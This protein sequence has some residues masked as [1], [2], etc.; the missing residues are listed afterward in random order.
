MKPQ[1]K[2]E[3]RLRVAQIL[4]A[5]LVLAQRGRCFTSLS[6]DE[7][8]RE[9]GFASSS[10]I[11]HHMGT[12]E[13]LKRDIMREAIRRECLPV[14]A[15]GLALGDKRAQKLPPELKEKALHSLLK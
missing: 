13:A 3:H 5:A 7:I 2:I 1:P 11:T 12:M 8:A 9:A 6:R 10:L 15:Q 4:D 14:I